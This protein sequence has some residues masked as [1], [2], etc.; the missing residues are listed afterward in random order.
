M[1]LAKREGEGPG[2]ME[3]PSRETGAGESSGKDRLVF[4]TGKRRVVIE[5]GTEE[6]VLRVHQKRELKG[7]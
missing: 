6:P 7:Q 2:E 3:L 1:T 4:R 5:A